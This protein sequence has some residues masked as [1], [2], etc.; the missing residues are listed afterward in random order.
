[1]TLISDVDDNE[2][3]PV[4]SDL[5]EAISLNSFQVISL[6]RKNAASCGICQDCRMTQADT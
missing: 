5:H 4:G 6:Q 2:H 1:M 3:I